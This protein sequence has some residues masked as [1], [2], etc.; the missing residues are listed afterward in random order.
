[1][2]FI[3]AFT[4]T[5]LIGILGLGLIFLAV[6]I[7][8][9]VFDWSDKFSDK[10]GMI[11][12]VKKDLTVKASLYFGV[13]LLILSC[14][15]LFFKSISCETKVVVQKATNKVKNIS[16]NVNKKASQNIDNFNKKASQMWNN[17]KNV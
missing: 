15:Y 4:I 13:F 9:D 5:S 10:H 3:N 17:R 7:D 2:I 14:F 6:I 12:V 8:W 16:Q 1:M 11:D